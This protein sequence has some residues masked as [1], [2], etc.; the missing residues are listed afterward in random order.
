V[1]ELDSHAETHLWIADLQ[2]TDETLDWCTQVLSGS[3]R[4]DAETLRIVVHRRRSVVSRALLR[5]LLSCYTGI[6]PHR[7]VIER[8]RHGKPYVNV[9][10]RLEFSVAHSRDRVLYGFSTRQ[11]GV[12]VE[13][14]VPRTDLS[15]VATHFFTPSEQRLLALLQPGQYERTFYW[16]WTAKEAYL[17]ALG[18]GLTVP[19][20]SFSVLRPSLPLSGTA[21]SSCAIVDD[22]RGAKGATWIVV[23]LDLDDP[24]VAALAVDSQEALPV[25]AVCMHG[26][27][28]TIAS[29]PVH[30]SGG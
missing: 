29:G 9:G 26:E 12:D 6:E 24:Y 15:S 17:K 19:L 20:D 13:A 7:Q 27:D 11:L 8:G 23:S 5:V 10:H 28:L 18:D 4:R 30:L 2:A 14:V 16:I 21:D 22:E 1:P 25:L 3:E